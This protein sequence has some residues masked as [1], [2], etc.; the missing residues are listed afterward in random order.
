MTQT[1]LTECVAIHVHLPHV[2]RKVSGK[3]SPDS[4]GPWLGNPRDLNSRSIGVRQA[5]EA[6]RKASKDSTHTWQS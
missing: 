4:V 6:G 5:A 2:T 1:R 3:C